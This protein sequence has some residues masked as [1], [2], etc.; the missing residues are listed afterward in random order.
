MPF[1]AG[2]RHAAVTRTADFFLLVPLGATLLAA[3]RSEAVAQ[4]GPAAKYV[5]WAPVLAARVLWGD[6]ILSWEMW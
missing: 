3:R 2:M 6:H 4:L 5:I 1:L